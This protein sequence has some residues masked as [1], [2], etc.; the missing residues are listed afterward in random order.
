MSY[1][2]DAIIILI[3][4]FYVFISAKK[5]FVRTLIEVVGFVAAIVIAFTVS[6]PIAEVS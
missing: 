6:T 4:L 2:L 3:V 1:I 5:G